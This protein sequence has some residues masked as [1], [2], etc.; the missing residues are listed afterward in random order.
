MS[1]AVKNLEVKVGT[2]FLRVP[3]LTVGPGEI[4]GVMGK[5]GS[6]Q[7]GFEHLLREIGIT[8]EPALVRNKLAMPPLGKMSEVE[9]W[10]SLVLRAYASSSAP[11]A[12]QQGSLSTP[13]GRRRR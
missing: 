3:E 6:K 9:N 1:L 8:L 11:S 13:R 10:D 5:S 2:F 12:R 7:S 4:V